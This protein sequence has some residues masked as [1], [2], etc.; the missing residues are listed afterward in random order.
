M[1]NWKHL[2]WDVV[3]GWSLLGLS[4]ALSF[5]QALPSSKTDNPQT[6]VSEND[7]RAFVK[8]YVENQKIRQQ[9]EPT[10]QNT[11]D[12]A[13]SKPI[14]DE[15]NAELK[16]ALAKEN[17]TI[18]RYNRIYNLVNNDEQLRGK[19]LKMIEEERRRST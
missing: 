17:L 2:F 14:Q 5:A 8:A 12:P 3:I 18:E 11:P 16:K 6:S 10:L 19:A 4:A 9:Y 15:A 13:K 1:F 7:L